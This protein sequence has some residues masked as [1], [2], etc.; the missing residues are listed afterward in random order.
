MGITAFLTIFIV[1]TSNLRIV[2]VPINKAVLPLLR[3]ITTCLT[4]FTIKDRV[5]ILFLIVK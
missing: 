5:Q 1:P 4:L 3:L 2:K